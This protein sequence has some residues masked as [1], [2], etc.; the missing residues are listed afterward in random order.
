MVSTL[1]VVVGAAVAYWVFNV[2]S[3][4]RRNVAAAKKTGLPYYLARKSPHETRCKAE[5]L[6]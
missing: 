6:P 2:L 1:L 3:A 4:L 5:Q